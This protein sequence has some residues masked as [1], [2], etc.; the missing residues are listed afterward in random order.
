MSRRRVPA[1]ERVPTGT[2]CRL[3]RHPAREDAARA[4]RHQHGRAHGARPARRD[5]A[6]TVGYLARIAPEKG[7][8][9]LCEA[10]RALRQRDARGAP[11]G[12][13]PRAIC[14][15]N[16]SPTSTRSAARCANGDSAT[17]S[18]TAAKSIARRRPRSSRALDV[19]S[20][21]ATYDEPKG[22]FLLEAHGQR[23]PGGAAA[24]AARF[25]RSCRRQAAACW[26]S[27]RTIRRRSPTAFWRCGEIP[28]R[29][30]ALGRPERGR[31]ARALRRRRDGRSR[32]AGLPVHDRHALSIDRT[33]RTHADR[34]SRHEALSHS[35]GR[36]A[37]SSTDISL[38]LER[39]AAIAIM[40][41]SGSGKSTLLYILG[42]LEPPSS[43]TVTLDGQDPYRLG[44]R[45]QAAFRNQQH[46]LRLPGSLA[47]AA[48]LGARERARADVRGAARP[49]PEPA[50]MQRGRG[51]C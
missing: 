42:A 9:A 29:A 12:W 19:F 33:R 15:R 16:T 17:S 44:E 7:L 21:P 24:S 40:G 5:G 37:P 46:R 31:R 20:V 26:S 47:A 51:R 4:A 8:H 45:E 30:A 23:R 22:M 10:Y 14:R 35:A 34:R 39:G 28:E 6:F 27:S 2:S 41:P 49:T 32:R 3:S 36:A 1:G 13:W 38:S 43:G 18:S 25:P 48:M 11:R 50:P